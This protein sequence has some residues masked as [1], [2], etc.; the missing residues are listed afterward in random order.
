[1]GTDMYGEYVMP[2]LGNSGRVRPL[3]TRP[4]TTTAPPPACDSCCPEPPPVDEDKIACAALDKRLMILEDA[5][6]DADC[7]TENADDETMKLCAQMNA[8]GGWSRSLVMKASW[9]PASA[10]PGSSCRR[11]SWLVWNLSVKTQGREKISA[12]LLLVKFSGGGISIVA[13]S[14]SLVDLDVYGS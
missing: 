11:N 7:S 13:A 6:R 14:T 1:M 3:P 5:M 12:S 9:T 4:P 2:G 8:S 10:R